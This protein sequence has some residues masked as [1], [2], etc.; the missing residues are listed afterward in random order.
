MDQTV[1]GPL[2]IVGPNES[3]KALASIRASMIVQR[4][5]AKAA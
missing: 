3:W 1:A 2:P 5:A 4:S